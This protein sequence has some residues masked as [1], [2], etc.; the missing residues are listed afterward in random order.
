VHPFVITRDSFFA[1]LA[2]VCLP[3][4]AVSLFVT[5]KGGTIERVSTHLDRSDRFLPFVT[6]RE[7]V[8]EWTPDRKRIGV[9]G[10]ILQ[11]IDAHH[12]TGL[13]V[14]AYNPTIGEDVPAQIGIRQFP[15]RTLIRDIPIWLTITDFF[16]YSDS[17]S[18]GRSVMT[19]G[20]RNDSAFAVRVYPGNT[21][22]KFVFLGSGKDSTGD[23]R[24]NPHVAWIQSY[25]REGRT[26]EAYVSLGA[27]R[28][29]GER[30]L[31]CLDLPH[32]SVRWK[33]PVAGT[34]PPG[35]ICFCFSNNRRFVLFTTGSPSQ[36]KRDTLFSDHYGYFVSADTSGRVQY[37]AIIK[38]FLTGAFLTQLDSTS[39]YLS[40]DYPFLD[41]HRNPD[42]VSTSPRIAKVTAEGGV[43]N[44][45]DVDGR[46]GALWVGQYNDQPVIY[47]QVET[48]GLRVYDTN[49]QLIAR[50]DSITGLDRPLGRIGAAN[51]SPSLF[52]LINESGGYVISS[53]F[54]KLMAIPS[55]GTN[56][57]QLMA[58][59]EAGGVTAILASGPTEVAI[60]TVAPASLWH[61][62]EVL[63]VDYRGIIL[64]VLVGLTVLLI[65]V[66]AFRSRNRRTLSVV[67][68]QKKE[69]EVTHAALKQAQ[70]KLVAAEKY[71][72]A[73]D[74]AGGFA[75]EIR[76]ALFPAE[77][78]LLK[79]RGAVSPA[80]GQEDKVSRYLAGA[81]QAVARAINSTRLISEYTKLETQ[82]LPH[83]I[84]VAEVLNEVVRANQLRFSEQGVSVTSQGDPAI[85]VIANQEQL[86]TAVNN[87]VSNALDAVRDD[88]KGELRLTWSASGAVVTL[89]VA[90]NGP[91]VPPDSVDRIFDTFYSTKPST[92]TGLGLPIARKIAELYGG[93]LTYRR[94]PNLSIFSIALPAD[95]EDRTEETNS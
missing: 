12:D 95:R 9:S 49:L 45:V 79:L 18:G 31:I 84:L 3:V 72:Q 50:S 87:L 5:Q 8:L 90:D 73:K 37:A 23:G 36:G 74:I 62:V 56:N 1:R 6:K 24:W 52:S 21:L 16:I 67:A 15:G 22:G 77:A 75:H 89:E 38:S 88:M 33:L 60:A 13:F 55:P 76:N 83:R 86:I 51:D 85:A 41:I 27:S 4:L 70:A 10:R 66:N 80:A 30:T 47:A 54:E 63:Y 82:H 69:L 64:S 53:K 71:R 25:Q 93:T 68:S 11:P 14:T 29:G 81:S 2:S 42:S 40:Y 26:C 43:T 91:G 92:G 32:Q 59:D 48:R 19:L 94:L 20:Y 39:V 57:L 58:S 28:D 65:V 7:I 17:A 44:Q 35:E 78:A 61:S 46:I 34:V